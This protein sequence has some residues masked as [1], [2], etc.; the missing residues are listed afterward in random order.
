MIFQTYYDKETKDMVEFEPY[1]NN[2]LTEFFENSVILDLIKQGKCEEGY[3]GVFGPHI[4][5]KINFKQDGFLF[6]APNL[7]KV[8]KQY[9]C[10]VYSF[11]SRRKQENIVLQAERYHPG[12]V[13]MMNKILDSVGLKL[14]K[15]L[16]KIVLFN[17][18]VAKQNFWHNYTKD[19]LIPAMNLLSNMPEAYQDSGYSKISSVRRMT[20]EK[21]ERFMAAF[22][23]PHYPYHPFLCERLPSIYLE[24]HPE[25]SFKQIF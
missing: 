22:G 14:P 2:N 19:L 17:N 21:T 15:K 11:C 13:D 20:P 16:S 9:D 24:L 25:Y 23:K 10:D 4:R 12:F 5:E 1:Y 6:N 3:F 7:Y 18:L 8:I